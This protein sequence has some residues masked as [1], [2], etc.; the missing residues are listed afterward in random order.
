MTHWI[1]LT[2][3][4]GSGKSTVAELF[5]ERHHILTIDSDIIARKLTAANGEAIPLIRREFGDDTIDISGSLNRQKM[6]HVITQDNTA[7][8]RLEQLLHPM[9]FA[10]IKQQQTTVQALY[11][12]I[13]IPLLVEQPQFM[14]LSERVLLVDCEENLQIERIRQRNQWTL[15][16]A[17]AALCLQATREQRQAIADDIILNSGSLNDLIQQ[18]DKLHQHYLD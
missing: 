14:G 8:A 13:A 11:A 4:I 7:K 3:G 15:E 5:F 16:Q 10:E 6:R 18:V 9:I 1:A 17:T 2:G 12:F